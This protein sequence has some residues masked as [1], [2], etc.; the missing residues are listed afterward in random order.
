QFLGVDRSWGLSGASGD[1]QP[2]AKGVE[3]RAPR[4]RDR[5]VGRDRAGRGRRLDGQTRGALDVEVHGQP[6]DPVAVATPSHLAEIG[7]GGAELAIGPAPGR[8]A[9][10]VEDPIHP[11]PRKAGAWIDVVLP[12]ELRA[13]VPRPVLA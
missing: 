10:L 6:E 12:Q 13:E 3:P 11:G 8:D 7:R 1:A 4:S 5:R 2:D 9:G